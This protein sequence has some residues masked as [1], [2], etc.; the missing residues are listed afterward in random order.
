[1]K[2]SVLRHT[3][4]FVLTVLLAVAFLLLGACLPQQPIDANV[5]DS[6]AVMASEGAYPFMADRSYASMQ[7]R[8][9]DALI[10]M[11]SKST[12][13]SQW[14]TIFTNPQF[15]YETGES[16]VDDLLSYSNDPD[17]EPTKFYVQYWMGFRPVIRLLLCFLDYYQILRYTAV[18][19]FVLWVAVICSMA[20]HAGTKAAFLFAISIILVRPHVIAA[21]LQFSCCFFIAFLAMLLIP[22]LQKWPAWESLFFLELGILTQ[23]FDFYT[24]PVLTFVLPMTY[25]YI[26]QTQSGTQPDL[27]QIG[28]NALSW[29]AGY[30]LMWLSKLILTSLLTDVN[31]L[32]TGFTSFMGRIGIEKTAGM[33]DYYNP[34]AALRTVAASLYSDREGKLILFGVIVLF[35]L[36]VLALFL[37]G[38]HHPRELLV[39][40]N[41]LVLAAL[42][43]IWFMAAAQPTANHHWFQ[44]R[45]IAATFWAGLM[46]VQYLLNAP[47]KQSS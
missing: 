16:P 7:D 27:K 32:G 44:Y 20:N 17:P 29:S 39:H 6:A 14:E 25:L 24:T 13:I 21:S 37:R 22:K 42:P 5:R 1:M 3:C 43:I 2:Q 47:T 38:K 46:Y 18:L 8:V 36:L 12:T 26:L 28:K 23:Y 4:L 35:F 40:R 30:G 31:G 33:E 9:T 45:G 41:L 34:L 10:L 19:F 11:E 15:Q